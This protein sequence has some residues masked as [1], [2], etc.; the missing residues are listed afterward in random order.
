VIFFFAMF[1]LLLMSGEVFAIATKRDFTFRNLSSKDGLIQNT[2]NALHQ[3]A[4]GFIWIGTQGGL[5]RYDGFDFRVYQNDPGVPD[6]IPASLITCITEHQ[7][8]KI[9]WV[10]TDGAGLAKIDLVTGKVVGTI[11]V[12]DNRV[13]SALYVNGLGLWTSTANGVWLLNEQTEQLQKIHSTDLTSAIQSFALDHQGQLW[14]GSARGELFKF[15]SARFVAI[16]TPSVG[17][18]RQI[19]VDSANRL[20]LAT[21]RG[22]YEVSPQRTEVKRW[23]I[24]GIDLRAIALAPDGALWVARPSNGL[25]RIDLNSAKSQNFQSDVL[26]PDSAPDVNITTMLLDKSGQ[27]WVGSRTRGVM[28]TDTA[29][30]PF[31]RVADQAIDTL[32]QFEKR[33]NT[34]ALCAER[35]ALWYGTEFGVLRRVGPTGS[36]DYSALLA[37]VHGQDFR[38]NALVCAPRDELLIGTSNGAYSLIPTANGGYTISTLFRGQQVRALMLASDGS[39]WVG[40]HEAGLIKIDSARKLQTAFVLNK[41]SSVSVLSIFEDRERRIWAGTM[42]GIYLKLPGQNSWQRFA[43]SAAPQSLP[44]NLV[45]SFL[46]TRDGR[47]WIGTHSGLARV[48]SVQSQAARSAVDKNDSESKQ[49]NIQFSRFTLRDGLP[50]PTVYCLQEDRLGRIWLSSNQGLVNFAPAR[51]QWQRF[52]LQDGL[53]DMEFN[54][55]ACANMEDGRLL[56]GGVN[57]INIFRAESIRAASFVGPVRLL[58]VRNL[59]T[60]LAPFAHKSITLGYHQREIQFEFASIDYR[61]Q[62]RNGYAYKLEGF[63]SEWT[64]GSGKA[65]ARYTNIPPGDYRFLARASNRDN[66]WSLSP[67]ELRLVV[68]KPWWLRAPALLSYAFFAVAFIALMRFF[69]RLYKQREQRFVEELKIREDRLRLCLWGSQDMYWDAQINQDPKKSV[70]RRFETES[71]LGTDSDGEFPLQ[72]YIET[73]VH[74]DDWPQ[75]RRALREMLKGITD[76]TVINHRLKRKD[77]SY[78]HVLA[79]GRVVRRNSTGELLQIAGT[80]RNVDNERAAALELKVSSRVID[81]MSEAVAVS[82]DDG[83]LIRVNAAFEQMT[84]Y[85]QAEVTGQSVSILQSKRHDVLQYQ[86]IQDMVRKDGRWKGEMWQRRKDGADILVSI[87]FTRIEAGSDGEALRL[88]VMSDI[89]DRKRAEDELRFLANYDALTGLPN[90]TMLLTRMARA[91]AR[92]KRHQQRVAI[93]F[94]DLDRFKQINDSMGHAT[95]DELLRGVADRMRQAVRDIDTVSRLAGDEFVLLMEEIDTIDGA[96]IAAQ[97]VLM[98][99]VEPFNLNGTDVVVSP[100]IGLAVFPDHADDADSLLKAAD[101]AMYAAKSA[102]R[103]T[104][105]L[106]ETEQSQQAV[107]RAE[108]DALLRRA[109]ERDEFEVYYQIA[110]DLRSGKPVGVEALLRWRHPQRGVVTPDSFVPILEENGCIVPVGLWV[111]TEALA[112]L[113]AWDVSSLS[114]LYISVNLSMLQLTRGDLVAEL[115]KLLSKFDISGERLTLELTETMVMSNPEQSIETLNRISDLGIQIAIDDF[116][117]GYSS[118]AYLKRLPIDKIKIDKAFVRDLGSDGDDTAITHSI[119]AL[120]QSLQ[121]TVVAEGVETEQQHM[122][123]RTFGCHQAQGYLYSQALPSDEITKLLRQKLA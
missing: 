119:I 60:S 101:L 41:E 30:A 27:L 112:Q 78:T 104:I 122:L 97:R 87:E 73:Q 77:G 40:L 54:G 79:R 31:K 2:V 6:S 43:A 95:G 83:N 19:S 56:F 37:S 100:S 10:G 8:K 80:A 18:I 21:E 48:D 29:S 85:E 68:Q 88:A 71:A 16:V 93:L 70:L 23:D 121:L 120:S 65:I 111:L 82:F 59:Q 103:N 91:M 22:L 24:A 94:L 117:T 75:V 98:Q 69:R 99:F 42:N 118:L 49:L 50:N 46:Q 52:E 15:A 36:E 20:L 26:S 53:Q 58:Q 57:G 96:E 107:E 1:A 17:S 9:L 92:A 74:P 32:E 114:K 105:R 3:D 67:I 102:G 63:E 66:Q 64:E 72:D 81:R 113:R 13:L 5:H 33:R 12:G 44:G 84:G 47:I 25:N 38:I 34:R 116:G 90:R 4:Q 109:L 76:E 51:N 123:L 35:D 14:A 45:R 115:P 106:F 7:S 39:I 28:L 55:G 110:M 89:T 62:A 11:D 61:N 86:S 108:N